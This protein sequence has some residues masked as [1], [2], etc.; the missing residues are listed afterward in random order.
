MAIDRK[1][2]ADEFFAGSVDWRP[3]G[4]KHAVIAEAGYGFPYEDWPQEVKDEYTYDPAG[5]RQLLADAGYPEGFQTQLVCNA[6]DDTEV[7]QIV[8]QYFKDIGV[9]MELNV[10]ESV[11]YSAYIGGGKVTQMMTASQVGAEAT[12]STTMGFFELGFVC[13]PSRSA[14][15]TAKHGI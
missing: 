15:S 12:H 8:Q 4:I 6:L 13:M 1:A 3:T 2:I 14:P 7:L 10:M 5:A 11:A 9:D